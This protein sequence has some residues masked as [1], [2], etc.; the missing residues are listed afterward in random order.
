MVA[1]DSPTSRGLPEYEALGDERN[2]I[3]VTL[4]RCVDAISRGDMLSRPSHAGIPCPAPE[5]QCQGSHIFEYAILP[6]AGDW[7]EVYRPAAVFAAPLYV[8]RGDETEGFVP[9]EVWSS[10][11][12]DALLAPVRFKQRSL[13][14]ELPGELSF[15]QLEPE[16]LVL[17]AIKRAETGD[18]LIVRFYNP[19]A[20]PVEATLRL[21]AVTVRGWRTWPRSRRRSFPSGAMVQ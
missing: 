8:R 9:Q 14:G 2:T 3:A 5:A 18:A 13:D 15:L 19:T 16:A 21:L 7:R 6:H 1:P 20:D 11:T 4:L 12:P 10:D 17:S